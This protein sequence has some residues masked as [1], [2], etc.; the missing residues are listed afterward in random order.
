MA[1]LK[2]PFNAS[3]IVMLKNLVMSINLVSVIVQIFH[4][5]KLVSNP[6]MDYM[7]SKYAYGASY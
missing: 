6:F 3:D 4:Q 2:A 5:L 7:T 1:L